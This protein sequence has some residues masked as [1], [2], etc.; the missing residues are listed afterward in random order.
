M[1]PTWTEP[2][3]PSYEEMTVF[4]ILRGWREVPWPT[5]MRDTMDG[6]MPFW[7]PPKEVAQSPR[8]KRALDNPLRAINIWYAYLIETGG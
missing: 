5:S 2:P 8:V 7:E 3:E 1:L 6:V 4:L